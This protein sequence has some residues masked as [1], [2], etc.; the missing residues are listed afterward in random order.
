MKATDRIGK[1]V[2]MLFDRGG[3]PRVS[4]L[5]QEREARSQENCSLSI[6]LPGDRSRAKDAEK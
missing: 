3:D 1:R 4:K 2:R 6:D 5:Q